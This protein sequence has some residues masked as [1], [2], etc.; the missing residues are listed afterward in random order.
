M[1]NYSYDKLFL[2]SQFE[3]TFTDLCIKK[4]LITN[5]EYINMDTINGITHLPLVKKLYRYLV[6]FEH[7]DF[8]DSIYDFSN[9]IELGLIDEKNLCSSNSEPDEKYFEEA[10]SIMSAYK[11]PVIKQLKKMTNKNLKDLQHPNSPNSKF[12]NT[13]SSKD[14]LYYCQDEYGQVL[15][16]EK[17]YNDILKTVDNVT[18]VGDTSLDKF[19]FEMLNVNISSMLSGIRNNIAYGLKSAELEKS[20]YASDF[21]VLNNNIPTTKIIDDTYYVI[22]TQLP[23]EYQIIPMPQTIQDVLEMRRSP[24]IKSFRKVMSEWNS[25]IDNN[26]YVAAQKMKNDIKKANDSLEKIGKFKRIYN[27]AI[28][29]TLICV[30][31]FIPI[32]SQ[33]LNILTWSQPYITNKFEEKHNWVLI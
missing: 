1:I 19:L 25:Y 24:Y 2:D 16:L 11:K 27:S 3:Q 30:G 23:N 28:T 4:G 12:W 17:N 13:I 14:I 32:L 20:A 26:D 15:G 5:S 7:I 6:L 22:K 8:S 10:I 9:L 33:I 31:G 21:L 29:R 18:G